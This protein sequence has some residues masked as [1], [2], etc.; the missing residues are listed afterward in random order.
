M[1]VRCVTVWEK[2]SAVLL[3]FA[4]ASPAL[5]TLDLY[6]LHLDVDGSLLHASLPKS[7]TA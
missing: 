5:R 6:V 1:G 3:R 2:M 7:Y 4:V